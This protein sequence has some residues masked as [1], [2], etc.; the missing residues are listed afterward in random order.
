MP[1]YNIFALFQKMSAKIIKLWIQAKSTKKRVKLLVFVESYKLSLLVVKIKINQRRLTF[2]W[3][4]S[5][6]MRVPSVAETSN[7]I[8]YQYH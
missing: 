1:Y 2:S 5:R 4:F 7:D 6:S 3:F 8:D